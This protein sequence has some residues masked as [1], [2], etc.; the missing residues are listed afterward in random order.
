MYSVCS[1]TETQLLVTSTH[2]VE[3]TSPYSSAPQLQNTIVRLG[4]QPANRNKT[5]W[6][7]FRNDGMVHDVLYNMQIF[8]VQSKHDG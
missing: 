2:S 4:R 7:H 6:Q 8:N 3:P 5:R 1:E